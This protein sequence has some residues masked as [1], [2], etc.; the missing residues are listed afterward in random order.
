MA[1][2]GIANLPSFMVATATHAGTLCRLLEGYEPEELGAY[3]IRP[4]GQHVPR[5]V[6]ALID[7]RLADPGLA[8]CSIADAGD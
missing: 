5:K 1:G 8:A 2:L 4:P 7:A 3:V 6:R